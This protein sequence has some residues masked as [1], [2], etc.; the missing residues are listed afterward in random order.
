M[1]ERTEEIIKSGLND[2][3]HKIEE[4]KERLTGKTVALYVGGNKAWSLVRAFEELGM[5]V[6]VRNKEWNERRL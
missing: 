6:Y 4:Y 2:V 1:M 5:D 3:E